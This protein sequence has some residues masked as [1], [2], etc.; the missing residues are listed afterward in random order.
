MHRIM[1]RLGPPEPTDILPR[2]MASF[3]HQGQRLAY[4]SFGSGSRAVILL[5]GIL[6]PARMHE[7]LARA[8]A[9]RGNRV[10]LL[11]LLGHGQSDR[12]R[13]MWR[14][15]MSTFG[16]EVVA[17]MDHLEL[18]EAVVGG[19]SL[20]AN[21]TLE[22]ASIAPQRL[23]GMILEM[24][25]LDNALLACAIFFTPIMVGLTFGEPLYKVFAAALRR[26]PRRPLPFYAG[27]GIDWLGQ[28]PGPSAA[29]IQGIF[30]GRVAPHRTERRTFTA[31]ALVIGH[32][33]DPIHPFSDAGMLADELPNSRL[34]EAESLVELR[35]APERLTAEIADFLD[36]VWKPRR[37]G[38]GRR[39]RAAAS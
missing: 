13:D 11:D 2:A 4:R 31:P 39:R 18:D 24:P 3:R 10:I 25:V 35:M 15:S 33:R 7:P 22:L 12:P 29:M 21:T 30:F 8:L 26:I 37:A 23:R 16:E 9:E 5:P 19:T 38:G 6:L 34:L 17:L 28:E 14:Y 36:E 1:R 27:I 20:G 32:H